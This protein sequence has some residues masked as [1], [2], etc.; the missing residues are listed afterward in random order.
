M[1]LAKSLKKGKAKGVLNVAWDQSGGKPGPHLV[2]KDKV[3][4]WF[5]GQA[6]IVVDKV[7]SP[8]LS[9]GSRVLSPR[10]RL[11]RNLHQ[12]LAV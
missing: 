4:D 12:Y 7:Q 1:G 10:A 9:C 2:G 11:D 3:K 8:S 5:I 6:I